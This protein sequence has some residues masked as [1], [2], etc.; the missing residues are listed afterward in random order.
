MED[1]VTIELFGNI[2][3]FRTDAGVENA[4]Q[5][6]DYLKNQV[7]RVE[8]QMSSS[9]F[10]TGH[11]RT[12]LLA[13]LN[14][15]NEYYKLKNNHEDFVVNLSTQLTSLTDKLNVSEASNRRKCE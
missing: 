11:F 15:T 6:V 3:K 10:D 14:I 13:S 8:A 12:L 4:K 5:V 1:I 9:T 2:Y 7:E